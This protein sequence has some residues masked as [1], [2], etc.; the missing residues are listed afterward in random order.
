MPGRRRA[1]RCGQPDESRGGFAGGMLSHK[2]GETWE[3]KPRVALLKWDGE[4]RL[5]RERRAVRGKRGGWNRR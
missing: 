5:G 1:P 2:G 4:A 3:G